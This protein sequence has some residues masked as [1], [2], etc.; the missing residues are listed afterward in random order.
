M[1]CKGRSYPVLARSCAALIV[2]VAAL[3]PISAS[4]QGPLQESPGATRPELPSFEP[5]PLE[6]GTILPPF[7]IPHERDTEG[8][9]GG[10]RAM[11]TVIQFSGN[12][13]LSDAELGEIAKPFT[14]R[15]LSWSD[16]QALR[17]DITLVNTDRSR[18]PRL[19]R[20]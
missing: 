20:R 6:P 2:L 12:T 15:A 7:P 11:I 8:L 16:I 18:S 3:A 13:A 4:A 9:S 10:L 14:G 5:P 17:D 19:R 1:P